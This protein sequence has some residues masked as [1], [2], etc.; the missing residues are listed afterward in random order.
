MFWNALLQKR[1]PLEAHTR[2]DVLGRVSE[3]REVIAGTLAAQVL[4]ESE[5]PDLEIAIVPG[6]R[7]PIG[8]VSRTRSKRSLRVGTSRTRLARR[9]IVLLF[10]ET[11]DTTLGKP[12][13]P[14]PQVERNVVLLV[15]R[16]PESFRRIHSR[17]LRVVQQLPGITDCSL[18]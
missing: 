9:P 13:D 2:V 11:L 15:H 1:H 18:K 4:H 5:V 14:T 6:R 10:A 8:A 16:H 12:S 17:R 7:T 3:N